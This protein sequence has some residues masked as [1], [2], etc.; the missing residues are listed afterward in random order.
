MYWIYIDISDNEI[1]KIQQCEYTFTNYDIDKF[2]EIKQT[3][4][5][6]GLVIIKNI[7]NESL[8]ENILECTIQTN[9]K[10]NRTR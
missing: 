3:F 10:K 8:I 6:Y 4:Q 5:K 1:E 7:I 2:S 9:Y